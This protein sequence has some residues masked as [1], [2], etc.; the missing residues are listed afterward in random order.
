MKRAIYLTVGL[1]GLAAGAF[2][3]HLTMRALTSGPQV[4][5]AQWASS[6]ATVPELMAEADLVVLVEAERPD[7]PRKFAVPIDPAAQKPGLSVDVTPFTH[8]RMRV[9]Q[10]FKGSAGSAITVVQTG[11]A[12]ERTSDHPAINL[13]FSDD[14]LFTQGGAHVLFLKDISLYEGRATGEQL[15]M[16]VNPAGRYDIRGQSVVTH[17][18]NSRAARPT[19]LAELVRQINEAPRQ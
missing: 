2:G 9:Q 16:I 18:E 3:T 19:S 14:P 10:V 13:V 8:T 5:H 6:A 7:A 15:F 17:S 1:L 12:L 4:V 11:G